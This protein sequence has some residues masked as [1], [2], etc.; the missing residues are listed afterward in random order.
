MIII[1]FLLAFNF[2]LTSKQRMMFNEEVFPFAFE[3]YYNYRDYG[4]FRMGSL[5][6]T[7]QHYYYLYDETLL[8]GHGVVADQH[9]TYRNSD[10][11]YMNNLIFGGIPYLICLIIYQSL[12]FIRP[13][14]V[15]RKDH[16]R[17]NRIDV[18]F[19]LLLFLFVFILNYKTT[20]LGTLH[21][22]ESLYIIVGSAYLIR[23]Y[24]REEEELNELVE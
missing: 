10:A 1:V 18:V 8:K 2:L 21:T 13:I 14:S 22:V 19:F 17:N 16:S 6:G 5:E 3:W 4:E 9:P 11:G 23:Y 15:A 12:Y 7:E 20:A 24:A